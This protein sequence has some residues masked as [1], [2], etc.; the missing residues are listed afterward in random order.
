[1][2]DAIEMTKDVTL[3]GWLLRT[4]AKAKWADGTCVRVFFSWENTPGARLGELILVDLPE[5][6]GAYKMI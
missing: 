5:I 1:M 4:G 6:A 3:N 2:T